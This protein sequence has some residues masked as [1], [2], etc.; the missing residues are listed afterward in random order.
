LLVYRSVF[1]HNDAAGI[2]TGAAAGP[3]IAR[4]FRYRANFVKRLLTGR[5]IAP[6]GVVWSLAA[7]KMKQRLDKGERP[8]NDGFF[9]QDVTGRSPADEIAEAVL[10]PHKDNMRREN[11]P[12]SRTFWSV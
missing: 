11:L 5:E 2:L 12:I 6:V 10:L 4:A 8:R 9:E 1:L 3:G 7:H